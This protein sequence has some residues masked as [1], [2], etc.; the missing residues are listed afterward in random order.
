MHITN[1]LLRFE[2]DFESLTQMKINE[3]FIKEIGIK[4]VEVQKGIEKRSKE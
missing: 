2:P 1:C 3:F 4:S